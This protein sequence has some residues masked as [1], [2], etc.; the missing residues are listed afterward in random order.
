MLY[1]SKPRILQFI[2]YE[3][4]ISSKRWYCDHAYYISHSYKPQSN[5][6]KPYSMYTQ[7]KQAFI[8]SAE[9][10][11]TQKYRIRDIENKNSDKLA[12]QG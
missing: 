8:E 1:E 10:Y 5:V 11:F 9:W 4:M 3:S 2:M 12:F 7:K 6:P